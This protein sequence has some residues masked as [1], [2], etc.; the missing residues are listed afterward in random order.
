MMQGGLVD[1]TT[2]IDVPEDRRIYGVVLAQVV[3]NC[4]KNCLGRVKLKLSWLPGF[5]PWARVA[6]L[7]A[8]EDRGAYFIPQ[9]GE[10]VLVAFNHGD[11]REPYVIGSVWNGKDRSPA[12]TPFDPVNKRLIRT[13]KGHEIEFDDAQ[14]SI[15]ITSADKQRIT[16]TPGKVEIAVDEQKTTAVT[17]ESGNITIKAASSIT[18]DA[19]TIN[20]TGTNVAVG[21][22]SSARIDGGSYCSIAAAQI[23]IG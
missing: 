19:P 7:M 4:D 12:R 16:L 10:E 13:P 23:F 9:V 18:L 5:E 22:S 2:Q 1:T 6:S 20:I 8:G 11:V 21:G 15:T 14:Q 17:L 3:E